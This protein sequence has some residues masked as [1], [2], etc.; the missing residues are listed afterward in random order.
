MHV[1]IYIYV[2]VYT[3]IYVR[4]TGLSRSFIILRTNHWRVQI[5]KCRY[6]FAYAH[7]YIYLHMHIYIYICIHIHIC[8]RDFTLA[9]LHN[10]THK[11][12]HVSRYIYMCIYLRIYIY[13]HI[14]TY[15]YV[16]ETPQTEEIG[17]KI[18][19]N[20]NFEQ[21]ISCWAGCTWIFLKKITVEPAQPEFWNT[22]KLPQNP[23][24]GFPPYSGWA[25]ATQKNIGLGLATCG[26]RG[27][28]QKIWK[29]MGFGGL[30]V[31]AL[32]C[33]EWRAAAPLLLPRAPTAKISNKFLPR[34]YQT[35]F[36]KSPQIFKQIFTRV[37]GVPGTQKIYQENW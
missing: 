3:Y 29:K 28:T 15:I 30:S 12:L 35:R 11:Q 22:P 13:I 4:E 27:S 26:T 20:P 34:T 21:Q 17:L 8:A 23:N 18:I 32:A 10:L 31:W 2:Y 5:Y 24:H 7:I 36:H 1:Y 16:Q 33:C 9:Q 19:L 6:I 37:N 25:G 14:Y